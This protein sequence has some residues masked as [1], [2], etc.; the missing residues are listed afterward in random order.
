MFADD[1][2]VFANS[3]ERLQELLDEIT[4]W[5]DRW[6]MKIGHAKCGVMLFGQDIADHS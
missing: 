3:G 5:S 6:E 4:E 1:I 2:V